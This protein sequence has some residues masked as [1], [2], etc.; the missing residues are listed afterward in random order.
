MSGYVRNDTRPIRVRSLFQETALPHTH[1]ECSAGL[2]ARNSINYHSRK[3]SSHTLTSKI[4]F[5]RIRSPLFCSRSFCTCRE[6]FSAPSIANTFPITAKSSGL[7]AISLA[8]YVTS[9]LLKRLHFAVATPSARFARHSARHVPHVGL[10][11]DLVGAAAARMDHSTGAVLAS[12]RT[13]A[14]LSAEPRGI[15]A[16]GMI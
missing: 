13:H 1:F 11:D 4:V 9:V 15:R 10:V 2:R 12:E 16:S 7:A 14:V 5:Y 3:M 8:V 6:R